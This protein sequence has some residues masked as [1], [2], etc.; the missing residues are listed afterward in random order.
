MKNLAKNFL[1]SFQNEA[2]EMDFGKE[3]LEF[4]VFGKSFIIIIL[5]KK[6]KVKDILTFGTCS[7]MEA[8]QKYSTPNLS[9]FLAPT[10]P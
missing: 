2:F 8:V 4:G 1:G 3:I 6:K 9:N 10:Q 7:V 5:L